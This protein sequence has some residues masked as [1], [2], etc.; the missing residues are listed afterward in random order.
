MRK[1][2]DFKPLKRVVL[3]GLGDLACSGLVLIVGPNSSGKSQLLQ[4]LY[5]RMAGEPR[6]LVVASDVQLEKPPFEPFLQCLQDEG[7]FSTFIDDAGNK[8]LRPQTMYLGSGQAVGQI[9]PQQAQQWHGGFAPES[10][11]FPRRRNEFLNYFGRLL[12]T[13]L[14]FR[15]SAYF[16]Q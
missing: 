15:S 12:V 1:L 7:Y 13:G 6:Q 16:S 3:P 4:D 8:H 2:S 14:F 10:T 5:H 9:Q 11:Q